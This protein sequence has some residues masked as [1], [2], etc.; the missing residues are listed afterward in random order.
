MNTSTVVLKDSQLL[1]RAIL[2]ALR[3]TD[4]DQIRGLRADELFERGECWRFPTV[5]FGQALSQMHKAGLIAVLGV[6]PI[7]GMTPDQRYVC[8]PAGEK[9][10]KYLMGCK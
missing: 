9:A 1:E 3:M 2:V 8:R 10:R 4:V 7:P 6:N 5:M